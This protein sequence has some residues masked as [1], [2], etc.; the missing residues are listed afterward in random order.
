MQRGLTV[1]VLAP[2]LINPAPW[3]DSRAGWAQEEPVPSAAPGQASG[4]GGG[5][6]DSVTELGSEV[7][8]V[9]GNWVE[10]QRERD[11]EPSSKPRMTDQRRKWC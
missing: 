8:E 9:G 6:L 4:C 3:N 1:S 7:T 5:G 11:R 10:R 2:I